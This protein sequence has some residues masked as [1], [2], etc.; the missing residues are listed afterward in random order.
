MFVR[1]HRAEAEEAE[2]QHCVKNEWS[3]FISEDLLKVG[4]LHQ[5]EVRDKVRRQVW[6]LQSLIRAP[7][8]SVGQNAV[9]QSQLQQSKDE[10]Q[11]WQRQVTTATTTARAKAKDTAPTAATA[12]TPT[13]PQRSHEAHLDAFLQA[14]DDLD[15]T[16]ELIINVFAEC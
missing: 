5:K 1:Q 2:V 12:T 4:S 10:P 13:A 14:T 8:R 6:C 9:G 16:K 11:H 3:C 15:Q 7:Q